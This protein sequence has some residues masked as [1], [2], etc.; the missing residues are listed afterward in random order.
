MAK[1]KFDLTPELDD[2]S[3][4]RIAAESLGEGGE[5]DESDGVRYALADRWVHLRRSNTEPVLRIIT[6]ASSAE[7]AEHLVKQVRAALEG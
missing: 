4:W 7:Q 3:R 2:P 6:E 1:A 5:F